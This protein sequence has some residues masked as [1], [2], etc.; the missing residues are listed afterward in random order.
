MQ[1]LDYYKKV[2]DDSMAM[3]KP[4]KVEDFVP[5][6]SFFASPPKWN[7]AHTSWFFEELLL[8]R[9]NTHYKIYHPKYSYLF[10]SYYN[11]LGERVQR[12]SRGDLSRP[13]VKEIFEYRN[14]VDKYMEEFISTNGFSQEIKDL[15]ILGL[16]HEQQH[17]ELFFTDLKYAFSVNPLF[18][19]YADRAFCE[20]TDF[21]DDS[22]LSIE[23]GLYTIGH[24]GDGFYFDNEKNRHKVFLQPY[25]IRNSLVRNAEF[26]DFIENN[27]YERFEFWH[28]EL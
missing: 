11:S 15:I 14:Y 6:P 7:L 17:Q 28:D 22:Y 16:N 19:A 18:P 1:R 25:K 2:R 5:Q 4:L 13:T 26:L 3:V 24:G 21:G 20:E 12:H 23:E 10:N 8:S 27:G 9:F